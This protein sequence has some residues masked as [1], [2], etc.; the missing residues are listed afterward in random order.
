MTKAK[1]L[2]FDLGGVLVDG[3]GLQM[4]PR[5]M[6][7]PL[8]AEDLRRKWVTSPAVVRFESGRCTSQ[9]FAAAFIEEWGL[10]IGHEAFLDE[11]RSWVKG[12]YPGTAELLAELRQRHTLACL[13][14]T[15]AVHWERVVK[16]KELEPVLE[17]A[18]ASHELGGMKPAVD[19]FA[20]VVEKLGCEA[21]EV[22]FFDDGP[23]NV[24][25]ARRAGLS[26]HQTLGPEH[27]RTVLVD[28]GLL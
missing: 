12:A 25:G 20:R 9:E 5:L 6:A 16:M 15:N 26:A 2:L 1:V 3:A 7:R 11:F 22:A 19:V 10:Q 18:F 24:D 21:G 28:L 17:R 13:S 8:A 27:L 4:L 23:E 14:N